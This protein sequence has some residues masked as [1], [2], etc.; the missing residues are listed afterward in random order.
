MQSK[1]CMTGLPRQ[2]HDGRTMPE[3]HRFLFLFFVVFVDLL[4][5]VRRAAGHKG[6]LHKRNNEATIGILSQSSM[7]CLVQAGRR[8]G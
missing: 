4:Q 7:P 8:V 6:E 5:A 3:Q 2:P 1:H